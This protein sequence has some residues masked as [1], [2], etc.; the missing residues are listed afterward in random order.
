MRSSRVSAGLAPRPGE[1]MATLVDDWRHGL[2][3]LVRRPGFT[4]AVTQLLGLGVGVTAAVFSLA[5]AYLLRPLPYADAE[6]I[7]FISEGRPT[8]SV[9]QALAP[10]HLFL[11]E[12]EA[13]SFDLVATY[14][15][16]QTIGF[17]LSGGERP[18]RVQGGAASPSFF[19]ILGVRSALGRTFTEQDETGADPV[20][21]LSHLLWRRSFG[22]N[23]GVVGR[24][25]DVSGTSRAVVGVLPSGFGFPEV[26]LWVPRPLY[27][28]QALGYPITATFYP[29]VLA[30]LKEGVSL[31]Q[32]R[33]EL[34]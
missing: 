17:D 22:G 19:E 27:V 4:V 34:Q 20:V 11:I 31:A 32:A 2:R 29:R 16:K 8:S 7:L 3:S 25:I 15:A 21:L 5:D 18:E 26:E 23:P 1:R 33:A 6:R 9:K 14:V 13:R 12:A 28:F 24:R 30:R 10:D